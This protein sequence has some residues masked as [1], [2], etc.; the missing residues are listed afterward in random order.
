MQA[1]LPKTPASDCLDRYLSE[2]WFRT[3]GLMAYAPLITIHRDVWATV[4]IRVPLHRYQPSR[5][6]RRMLRK[7][8]DRFRTE[9]GPATSDAAR[10]SLYRET[11]K[12]F[13]GYRYES[14][15]EML[16]A[17]PF[18]RLFDTRE[19]S[20]WDGDRLVATSYFDTGQHSVASLLGLYDPE[21]K[22]FGLGVYT[23]LLEVEHAV[24]HGYRYYYPGYVLVGNPWLD[25]KLRLQ[26]MQYRSPSG[27]WRTRA[28]APIR[29][30]LCNRIQQRR[31]RL[32]RA[33]SR[34]GVVHRRR[35]YPMFWMEDLGVATLLDFDPVGSPVLIEIGARGVETGGWI[36]EVS[37]EDG[38][39]YRVS[40][41]APKRGID[42]WI[43]G[44]KTEEIEDPVYV[45]EP[46]ERL[47]DPIA[48]DTVDAVLAALPSRPGNGAA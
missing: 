34:A 18:D 28:T 31:A 7:N 44:G 19:V 42:D 27:R 41:A 26:P 46:L 8:G 6:L 47:C 45:I 29:D 24:A 14:L 23:M 40:E 37:R 48:V 10:E 43:E 30:R 16:T 12:R 35:I 15:S 13:A 25:Y 38:P 20:V 21:Y 32:E 17:E 36:V 9:V 33:L 5:S 3:G 39:A 4:P 11:S 22:P 1:E 2:G